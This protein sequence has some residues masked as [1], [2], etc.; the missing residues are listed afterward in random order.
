MVVSSQRSAGLPSSSG[1]WHRRFCCGGDRGIADDG[2]GGDD[3]GVSVSSAFI[4]L[5]SVTA[6][7]ACSVTV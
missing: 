1:C 5:P 2:D 7:I 6:A 3:G 4:G